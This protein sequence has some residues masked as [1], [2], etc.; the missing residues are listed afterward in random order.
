MPAIQNGTA[1]VRNGE[2]TVR[3]VWTLVYSTS[4]G[5]LTPGDALTWGGDGE[6]ELI[7]IDTATKRVKLIHTAGSDLPEAGIGI[8]KSGSGTDYVV[9]LQYGPGSPGKWNLAT[10][11]GTP[12]WFH[13]AGKGKAF[14]VSSLDAT[15]T[16]T[17][18][19]AYDDPDEDDV[20]YG[21]TQ[22][23]TVH[24]QYPIVQLGDVD[25]LTVLSIFQTQIDADVYGLITG[26]LFNL[27]TVDPEVAGQLWSDAGT[28]KVSA[29]P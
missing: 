9:V 16:L 15:D 29:G 13:A 3:H 22:D 1:S 8:F 5:T 14:Q 21:I 2:Q 25:A 26:T 4:S 20:G 19:I 11:G 12:I 23:Y 28:V 10:I 18:T 27:P 6:G 24:R 17:L 7:S